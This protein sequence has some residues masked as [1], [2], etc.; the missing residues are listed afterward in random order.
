M[1]PKGTLSRPT[2]LLGVRGFG[3]K[4]TYS[5]SVRLAANMMVAVDRQVALGGARTLCA[6]CFLC[7]APQRPAPCTGQF[8]SRPPYP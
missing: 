5:P 6:G 1:P 7:R 3:P 8:S 2:V 4:W